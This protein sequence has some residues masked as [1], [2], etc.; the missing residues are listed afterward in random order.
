MSV[1]IIGLTAASGLVFSNIRTQEISSDRLI[2]SNLAREGIEL[3]KEIRDSNWLTGAVI[4]AGLSDGTDYSAIPVWTDAQF[5]GLDFTPDAIS[6]ADAVVKMSSTNAETIGALYVQG[7]SYP[8]TDTIYR[9]LLLLEP[10]CWD[11]VSADT[12]IVGE[13][14]DCGASS[15]VGVHITST[16]TWDKRGKTR[17]SQIVDEMYDWK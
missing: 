10:I 9:R 2:A 6:D 13:G 7:S 4:N 11:G 17:T 1:I 15:V 5:T 16:V 3:V 8:G 14:S 12:T